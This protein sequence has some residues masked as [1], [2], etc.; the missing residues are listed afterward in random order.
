MTRFL[1]PENY[2][3]LLF[4]GL[5]ASAMCFATWNFAVKIIGP[6]TSIIYLYASPVLTVLFA[7]LILGEELTALGLAG[8]VLIM[9]GLVLS[10]NIKLPLPGRKAHGA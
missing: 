5:A 4:L 9:I 10:Q 8:C 1:K 2:G 6:V 3:N 7:W